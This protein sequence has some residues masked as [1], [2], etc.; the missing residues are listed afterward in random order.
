MSTKRRPLVVV[1][2]L[3]D[4][5]YPE[6]TFVSSALRA[7]AEH[8]E[9][10]W[11]WKGYLAALESLR[12]EGRARNLFQEAHAALGLGELDPVKALSL[13]ETYRSHRPD[14]LP[15]FP[16]AA[17]ALERLAP[18][19]ALGLI[20]DGYL[21]TQANKF[22]ALG[23]GRFIAEPIFTESLGREHW[24]PD[25][26]AFKEIMRRHPGAKCAYVGDNLKKDFVAP[27]FLG[28]ATFHI[29]RPTGVHSSSIAPPGG[30]PAYQL[31]DLTQLPDLIR[32]LRP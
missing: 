3:D 23:A 18:D 31:R 19:H 14:S 11:G 30:A 20:S 12:N 32:S 25:P 5:L 10:E 26:L 9:S 4:T 6:A 22:E 27:N 2:D 15:W 28:W 24:K 13:L 7:A 29:L 17:S 16:D 8:A 21:P 1:F